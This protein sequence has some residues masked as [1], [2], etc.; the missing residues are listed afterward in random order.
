MSSLFVWLE[1]NIA[2]SLS[3]SSFSQD[4]DDA[5]AADAVKRPYEIVALPGYQ[6]PEG[7]DKTSKD[8][9][10][11][12][13]APSEALVVWDGFTA[14][15]LFDVI[16]ECFGFNPGEEA[17]KLGVR[18]RATGEMLQDARSERA[19]ALRPK[20]S[21]GMDRETYRRHVADLYFWSCVVWNDAPSEATADSVRVFHSFFSGGSFAENPDGIDAGKRKNFHARELPH[22]EPK[23]LHDIGLNYGPQAPLQRKFPDREGLVLNRSNLDVS[24]H[25]TLDDIEAMEL[26]DHGDL[27]VA[28][29]PSD[30]DEIGLVKGAREEMRTERDKMIDR[31]DILRN[32]TAL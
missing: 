27:T 2:E 30:R 12:S 18:V 21:V 13:K 22:R 7:F 23:S 5:R 31:R 29:F 4:R 32:Q 25:I 16:Y 24:E 11:L 14:Q 15:S 3:F 28:C 19:L 8:A 9:L 10:W 26:R 17:G 6:I 20:R 1:R